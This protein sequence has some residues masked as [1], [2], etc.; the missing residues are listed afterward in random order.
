ML[1]IPDDIP[2]T[3]LPSAEELRLLREEIVPTDAIR[4]EP[5]RTIVPGH[6]VEAVVHRPFGAHPTACFGRYDYDAEHLKLYVRH[7]RD[8]AGIGEYLDTYIRGTTDHDGYLAQTGG[9]AR[10]DE[11]RADPAL[12][13]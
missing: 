7:S 9:S 12:G 5:E 1:E 10:L 4:R 6:R 2:H 11:L 3:P 8:G 13:Y